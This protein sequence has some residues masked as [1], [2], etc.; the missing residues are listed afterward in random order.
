MQETAP[1]LA[2][3]SHMD[4]L[5]QTANSIDELVQ[6]MY[7]TLSYLTRKASFKSVNPAYPVT[8]TIPNAEPEQ[9]FQENT[10]ELVA[11]FLRKAKQL[12]YLISVLPSTPVGSSEARLGAEIAPEEEAEFQEL[13]AEIESVNREYL[14]AL[15]EAERMHAELTTSLRSALDARTTQR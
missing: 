9:V 2:E 5:T 14:D 6:I 8:Q 4:R 3:T 10:K 1:D 12:E 15:A 11:D 13:Q 7:S